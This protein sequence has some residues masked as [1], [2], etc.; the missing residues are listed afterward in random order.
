MWAQLT[1]HLGA[2]PFFLMCRYRSLPP[3]VRMMRTF[4]LEVLYEARVRYIRPS[5]I[6]PK[7][8]ISFSCLDHGVRT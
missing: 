6:V 8:H 3:G 7:P 2:E 1:P 4:W 5:V